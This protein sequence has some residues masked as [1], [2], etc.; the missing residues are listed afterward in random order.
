ME[1][2]KFKKSW[3]FRNKDIDEINENLP[4][5]AQRTEFITEWGPQKG[6]VKNSICFGYYYCAYD[7]VQSYS[8]EKSLMRVNCLSLMKKVFACII[9]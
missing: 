7:K 3:K 2:E 8:P 5:G 4:Y 9:I 6:W 1:E